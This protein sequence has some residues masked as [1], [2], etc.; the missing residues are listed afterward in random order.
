MSILK[1]LDWLHFKIQRTAPEPALRN[2][3][4]DGNFEFNA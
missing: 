2:W 4:Y 3:E 1:V